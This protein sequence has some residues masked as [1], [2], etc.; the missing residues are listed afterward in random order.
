MSFE[1]GPRRS[2]WG[3]VQT[4][5]VNFMGEFSI[6]ATPPIEVLEEIGVAA[7]RAHELWSEDRELHFGK[8]SAGGRL[9]I[10]M[11]DR[12]GSTIRTILPSEA[13][14]VLAGA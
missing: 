6:P 1:I 4:P 14:D 8:D 10:E 3:A 5:R 13:L 7:D 2:L 11:R 9:V 12:A